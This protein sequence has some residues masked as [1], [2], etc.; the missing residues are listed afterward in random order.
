M[1][2]GAM[3]GGVLGARWTQIDAIA[4]ADMPC[5]PLEWRLPCQMNCRKVWDR[6]LTAV[7]GSSESFRQII[8]RAD[9]PWSDVWR[10]SRRSMDTNQ[11]HRASEYAL[12][13]PRMAIAMPDEL[14]ESVGPGTVRPCVAVRRASGKSSRGRMCLGAMSGGVRGARW[15]QIG[16]IARADM[17]CRPLEWRLPCQ[18]NCRNVRVRAP[19]GR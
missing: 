7:C 6:A 1:C 10:G 18:V 5:R 15:T 9:V 14:Q 12:E 4:R 16:A 8:A 13:A 17:P 11:C 3:S 2:L 19:T